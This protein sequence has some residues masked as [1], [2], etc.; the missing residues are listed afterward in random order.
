MYDHQENNGI[1]TSGT[2]VIQQFS[3][4]YLSLL[5]CIQQQTMVYQTTINSVLKVTQMRA[6]MNEKVS[7]QVLALTS[8]QGVSR[9]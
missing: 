9:L 4:N 5:L 3:S 2:N 6:I 1:I 7:V 8:I